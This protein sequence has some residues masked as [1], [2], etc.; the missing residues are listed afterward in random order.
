MRSHIRITPKQ[1]AGTPQRRRG[2]DTPATHARPAAPAPEQP[3]A[4]RADGP[5]NR[6]LRAGGPQDSALYVCRCGAAFQSAV[7]ASV[8]CPHC[9]ELQA[10]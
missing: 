7:S 10:W 4:R 3:P 1:R 2:E 5:E 8:K 6:Q 9:G